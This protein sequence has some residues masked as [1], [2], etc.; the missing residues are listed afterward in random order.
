[1]KNIKLFGLQV[2]NSMMKL[3]K[4]VERVE[5][6]DSHIEKTALEAIEKESEENRAKEVKEMMEK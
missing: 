3:N 4:W 5:N 6:K 1:M 2:Q